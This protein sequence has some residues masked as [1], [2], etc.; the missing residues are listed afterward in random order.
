MENYKT[1][2][3]A[4]WYNDNENPDDPVGKYAFQRLRH[5]WFAPKVDPKFTLRRND[6]FYAIGRCLR[7]VSKV[8]PK[9]PSQALTSLLKRRG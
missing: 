1:N 6:K 9:A 3:A 2:T 8:V 7:V 5:T 4:V